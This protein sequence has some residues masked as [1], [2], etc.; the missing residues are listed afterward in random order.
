[1]LNNDTF[2]LSCLINSIQ[3]NLEEKTYLTG[4]DIIT[5]GELCDSL[6]FIIEGKAS[7]TATNL[8]NKELLETQFLENGDFIGQWSILH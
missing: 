7:V 4:N 2:R 5:E 1:M 6:T 3:Y 8:T